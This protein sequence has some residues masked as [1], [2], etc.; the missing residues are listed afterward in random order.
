MK[1]VQARFSVENE[2]NNKRNRKRKEGGGG[3]PGN[4]KNKRRKK[5][6]RVK[7]RTN[8]A[9]SASRRGKELGGNDASFT[10]NMFF[11]LEQQNHGEPHVGLCVC[12]S[13]CECVCVCVCVF[14]LGNSRQPHSHRRPSSLT[15]GFLFFFRQQA[16]LWHCARAMP[17][18]KTDRKWT[19]KK[20]AK[21]K[22]SMKEPDDETKAGRRPY[23]ARCCFLWR[24]FKSVLSK[25]NESIQ[26]STSRT[27]AEFEKR[28][29]R[30]LFFLL[31]FH[32]KLRRNR[33]DLKRVDESAWKLDK[34][35]GNVDN[36]SN[37]RENDWQLTRTRLLLWLTIKNNYREKKVNEST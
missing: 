19:R 34:K 13:W 7:S 2:S 28:L 8:K 9:I 31:G 36:R 29:V 6:P 11:F 37:G 3:E 18:K 32:R 33:F 25:G 21:Q 22:K 10:L 35:R 23:L 20:N 16:K 5:K 30:T 12:W 14:F 26:Q 24:L 15:N 1:T 4:R 27:I 17:R